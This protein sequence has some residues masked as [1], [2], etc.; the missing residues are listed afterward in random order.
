MD[1][2]LYSTLLAIHLT[3]VLIA[4]PIGAWLL[5]NTKGTTAHRWLGRPYMALMTIT[6]IA[7]LMMPAFVGPKLFNHF[8]FIHLFSLLVL[9]TVPTSILAIKRGDVRAH[10]SGM[11]GMYCGAILVA[12][13]F[14]FMPGRLMHN[15]L[16]TAI[17]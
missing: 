14:A 10:R 17:S 8:G 9:W 1:D 3:T 15:V 13:A 5:L 16:M 2:T 11:I 7:S 12:G 4:C 6:A